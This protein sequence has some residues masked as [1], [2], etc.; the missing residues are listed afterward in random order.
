MTGR[1][2]GFRDSLMRVRVRASVVPA[3]HQTARVTRAKA[4]RPT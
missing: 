4:G 3:S 2:V 1:F